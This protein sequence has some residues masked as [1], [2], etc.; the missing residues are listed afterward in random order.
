M[1]TVI[2]ITRKGGKLLKINFLC[3]IGGIGS[4]CDTNDLISEDKGRLI[5]AE[6]GS[7]TC[8][9]LNSRYLLKFLTRKMNC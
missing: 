1:T 6:D 3:V 9:S 2:S 7:G 5:F 4:R 8:R